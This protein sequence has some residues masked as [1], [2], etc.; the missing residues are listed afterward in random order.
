MAQDLDTVRAAGG[1][2]ADRAPDEPIGLAEEVDHPDAEPVSEQ[3]SDGDTWRAERLAR[4]P[5]K[6]SAPC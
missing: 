1:T 6:Q 4:L 5:N 3:A 2:A